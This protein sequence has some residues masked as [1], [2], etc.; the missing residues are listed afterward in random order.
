M[1]RVRLTSGH[2]VR[3]TGEHRVRLTG[4]HRVRLTSGHRASLADRHAD[5][6]SRRFGLIY[7][8]ILWFILNDAELQLPNLAGCAQLQGC[9]SP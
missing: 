3:L 6:I 8:T 1:H 2:G 9:N 4:E 5:T 7:Q